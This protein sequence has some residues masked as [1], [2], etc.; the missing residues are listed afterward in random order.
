ML[1]NQ[2]LLTPSQVFEDWQFVLLTLTCGVIM[3]LG[4]VLSLRRT[5]S[6]QEAVIPGSE[7]VIG[8]QVK[9]KGKQRRRKVGKR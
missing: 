8:G 7:A 9:N 5:R 6:T 1:T 2:V 4:W 3:L